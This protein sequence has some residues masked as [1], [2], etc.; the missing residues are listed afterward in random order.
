M[1]DKVETLGRFYLHF[2]FLGLC[3]NL[4]FLPKKRILRENHLWGY[5]LDWYDGPI[6]E[7]GLG[8]LFYVCT[9]DKEYIHR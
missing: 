2:D 3:W 1:S 6:H 7:F 9:H 8:P 4:H 5:R